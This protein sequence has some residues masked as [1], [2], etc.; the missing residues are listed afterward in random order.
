MSLAQAF[1]GNEQPDTPKDDKERWTV[2]NYEK[3]RKD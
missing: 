1:L 2:V 3:E